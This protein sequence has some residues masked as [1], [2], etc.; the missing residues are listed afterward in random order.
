MIL[1]GSVKRGLLQTRG[2]VVK[3]IAISEDGIKDII[4]K[5]TTAYPLRRTRALHYDVTN[6][7]TMTSLT[8]LL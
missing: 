8:P 3:Y 4:D 5:L 7:A 1:E 6:P 2:I